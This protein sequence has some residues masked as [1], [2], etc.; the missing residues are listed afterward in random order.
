VK[1]RA[2]ATATKQRRRSESR[3]MRAMTTHDQ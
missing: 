3:S 2:S 1:P